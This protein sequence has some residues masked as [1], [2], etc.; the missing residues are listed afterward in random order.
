MDQVPAFWL[1]LG[2][3]SCDVMNHHPILC[4]SGNQP[5]PFRAIAAEYLLRWTGEKEKKLA[6]SIRLD[7]PLAFPIRLLLP[8]LC[9]LQD[10]RTGTCLHEFASLS[11]RKPMG[12]ARC[13]S[14][15]QVGPREGRRIRLT[16]QIESS[17][18]ADGFKT[19]CNASPALISPYLRNAE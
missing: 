7:H 8:L 9:C 12:L 16:H 15:S 19:A 4:V 1:R 5:Q 10:L 6:M 3:P 13:L 17:F 14:S 18:C 2:S 11:A